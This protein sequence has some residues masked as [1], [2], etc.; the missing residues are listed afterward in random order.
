M[1]HEMSKWDNHRTA[2]AETLKRQSKTTAWLAHQ[3]TG[4]LSRNLLYTY[5]RGECEISTEKQR[6]INKVLGL[7]F[8]DE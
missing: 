5:L 6:S 2:V 1:P 8:T 7:R 3:L 4:K